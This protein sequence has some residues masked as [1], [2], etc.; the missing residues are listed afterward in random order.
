MTKIDVVKHIDL[1][2]LIDIEL[3]SLKVKIK[4]LD[5]ERLKIEQNLVDK[6]KLVPNGEV[7]TYP[8]RKPLF[9]ASNR[10]SVE[11]DREL[12]IK[13]VKKDAEEV[14]FLKFGIGAADIPKFKSGDIVIKYSK[15]TISPL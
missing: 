7:I 8:I 10:R 6:C 3:A 12:A 11:V 14:Q 15:I 5:K 13:W 1:I 4:A 9:K 2:K